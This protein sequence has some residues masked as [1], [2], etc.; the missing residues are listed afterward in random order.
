PNTTKVCYNCHT[1]N[2]NNTKN[3][4]H[5]TAN[6]STDCTSC[7]TVNAWIPSTFNHTLYFP[8]NSGKHSNISCS[9]CHTTPTNYTVF[10]CITASCHANAHNRSQGSAGC[11]KCHPTGKD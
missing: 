10:T 4:A 8:I 1:T 2:Y 7:H 9:I 5:K 11:Y 6:Y 3:P